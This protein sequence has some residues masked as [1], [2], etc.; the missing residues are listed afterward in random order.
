MDCDIPRLYTEVIYLCTYIR[1]INAFLKWQKGSLLICIHVF[2]F[3]I[4]LISKK[5][6]D[7]FLRLN[8][9]KK[10]WT[11]DFLPTTM[12]QKEFFEFQNK[13]MKQRMLFWMSQSHSPIILDKHCC[14]T[15]YTTVWYFQMYRCNKAQINNH[16]IFL[17]FIIFM[18]FAMS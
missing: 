11:M 6:A 5:A 3:I 8:Y 17:Q 12:S 1:D 7:L 18:V 2:Q 9:Y 10:M 16:T 14:I 4:A 13:V 15:V